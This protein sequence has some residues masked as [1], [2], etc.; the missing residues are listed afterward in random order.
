MSFEL[1]YTEEDNSK[2]EMKTCQVLRR[3]IVSEEFDATKSTVEVL[4]QVFLF[5][6]FIDKILYLEIG[7]TL[8]LNLK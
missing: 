5:V 1:K 7:L 2:E 8:T 4:K 3:S 6:H